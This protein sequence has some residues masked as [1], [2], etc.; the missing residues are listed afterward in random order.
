MKK[1]KIFVIVALLTGLLAGLYVWFF[2]YNK[3][4]P[5]YETAQPIAKMDADSCYYAFSTASEESEKWLG[6]VIEISGVAQS[7]E[8]A[9]SLN[10]LVFE[11]EVDEIFGASGIRCS[12]LPEQSEALKNLT[13]PKFVSVKGFVSGFNGSDVI[14]EHCSFTNH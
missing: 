12:F 13:L 14:L 7:F 2:V 4:H 3:A 9:D 10:I 6:Q 1:F 11:F 5:D 8:Q